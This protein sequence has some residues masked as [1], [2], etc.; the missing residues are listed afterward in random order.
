[1]KVY[2]NDVEIRHQVIDDG[3]LV[4]A[5]GG[6]AANS[7]ITWRVQ[8]TLSAGSFASQA[9]I[10]DTGTQYELDNGIIALRVPK[11]I[12]CAIAATYSSPVEPRQRVVAPSQIFAPIQG[13]RHLDGTW[14]GTGPNY[15][16][17][18]QGRNDTSVLGSWNWPCT[19][20]GLV[21]IVENGPLRVKVKI[22]YNGLRPYYNISSEYVTALDGPNGYYV[23]TI[24]LEA[25]QR[26][27]RVENASNGRPNW[28]VAMG[29][30]ANRGRYSGHRATN[31][32]SGHRYN[33]NIYQGIQVTAGVPGGLTDQTINSEA[34]INLNE[35]GTRG[36]YD[37]TGTTGHGAFD[38]VFYPYNSVWFDYRY[39]AGSYWYLYNSAG[40]GSSQ[41][42]GIIQTRASFVSMDHRA[43]VWG[44][45]AAG[46]PTQTG[47]FTYGAV[48][49]DTAGVGHDCEWDFTIF[50]GSKA[51]DAPVDHSALTDPLYSNTGW[52]PAYPSGTVK[53]F[54]FRNGT[55][56]AFKQLDWGVDFPDPVGGFPG[57]HL[58][59][60][61]TEALIANIEADH[62]SVSYYQ[63]LWNGDSAYRDVWEAFAQT[64]NVKALAIVEA[65]LA[66]MGHGID[67]FVNYGSI[68][69]PAW[70]YWQ[71]G[72]R[73]QE[74]NIRIMA[75]ISLDQVRPFLTALKKKQLKAALST[76]GHI[77]WDNDF[78]PL[79]DDGH[80]GIHFGNT[81]MISQFSQQRSQFTA[82]L[83]T[84]PQFV[85]RFD[86]VLASSIARFNNSV[87][88]SGAPKDCPHY[89]G[90]LI[91][92]LLDV[93]RQL[94]VSG[95]ADVFATDSPIYARMVLLGEYML[96]IMTPPQSRY[97]KTISDTTHPRKIVCYGDGA[98]EGSNLALPLIMG[99]RDS[100]PTLSK[101]LAWGWEAMGKPLN[102][103]YSSSGLKITPTYLTQDPV[104]GD[105]DIAGFATIFR[106]SW[107]D[108]VKESMALLLHGE[109]NVDHSNYERGSP[110]LYL[111][112][113]PVCITF[114]S[115]YTPYT[116]GPWDCSTYIPVSKLDSAGAYP[117]GAWNTYTDFN[118]SCG[119]HSS[120]FNDTYTHSFATDRC[121]VTCSFVVSGWVRQMT[122]YRDDLACPVV[123]FRDSD[124]ATGD[125]VY[126]IMMMAKDAVTLPDSST[127]TPTPG[128]IGGTPFSISN[129]ACFRFVGQWDVSWDFY[130]F[131]PTA[132]AFIGVHKHN[133]APGTES[134]QFIWA[135]TI[136][137]FEEKQ[138]I[139]RIKTAGPCDTVIVPYRTGSRPAG[140]NVTQ[141]SGGPNLNLFTTASGN[142][143]LPA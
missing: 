55:A 6:V 87:V 43:G 70:Q 28:S 109:A 8:P 12:P 113:E 36:G 22:T 123:R 67:L 90:A 73:F 89:A 84:H 105:A 63:D 44:T 66:K 91:T 59:R 94:Q 3:I 99:F 108:P 2:A 29:A 98:T 124:T 76:M 57:M 64:S 100:N 142:R 96:Q 37:W 46:T 97:Q 30:G 133:W 53:A 14:V 128:S 27:F 112:G 60:A 116:Y 120:Y 85:D 7:T 118:L 126:T 38:G 140:L 31:I 17:V 33:G 18:Y 5:E 25:G 54:A 106:S 101:R 23:C 9:W 80:G 68:H 137:P 69:Y 141:V 119:D 39:D 115:M 93:F 41:V 107:G 129:G 71:G 75:M 131:G 138:Y 40:S 49:L 136:D 117:G 143:S 34:E 26:S 134:N 52:F 4:R 74:L 65:A 114:G 21:E 110:S 78:V 47:F 35:T 125:T 102:S 77:A 20:P 103:F 139:L 56:Q 24:T 135:T 122:F 127:F 95:Y 130:Y 13:I 1:M 48:E 10:T 50:L 32:A 82:T 62:D 132:E 92:A 72:L 42:W 81:N 45:P 86:N 104:L 83:K 16:T 61:D 19:V 11:T 51:A 121:D 88:A 111:L 58:T 15:L 79:D